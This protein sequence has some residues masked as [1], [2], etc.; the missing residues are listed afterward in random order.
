[1]ALGHFNISDLVMLKGVFQAAR[2]VRVAVLV[3]VSEAAQRSTKAFPRAP[4]HRRA[5]QMAVSLSTA[6]ILPKPNPYLCSLTDFS[7][8]SPRIGSLNTSSWLALMIM[9]IQTQK[10]AAFSSAGITL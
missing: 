7:A 6:V 4:R 1:M 2:E 9:K 10:T 3:G 8:R 5:S